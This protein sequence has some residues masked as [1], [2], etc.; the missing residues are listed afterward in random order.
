M[1]QITKES[2]KVVCKILVGTEVS[3]DTVEA[4]ECVFW[5]HSSG[6]EVPDMLKAIGSFI[7]GGEVSVGMIE[8]NLE[9]G[10]GL[11]NIHYIKLYSNHGVDIYA[12]TFIYFRDKWF[13]GSVGEIVEQ[14]WGMYE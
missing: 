5:Q 8:E 6:W 3:D 1:M 2:L 13:W 12:K 7:W 4:I 14:N 11:N 9:D 10:N